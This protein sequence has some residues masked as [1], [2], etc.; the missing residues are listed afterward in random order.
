MTR[1]VRA[2]PN[3]FVRDFRVNEWVVVR[4]EPLPQMPEGLHPTWQMFEE[5][6]HRAQRLGTDPFIFPKECDTE[7]KVLA[8]L[9]A[10]EEYVTIQTDSD[11]PKR[12]PESGDPAKAS[13]DAWW[14]SMSDE[15]ACQ[16]TEK[17]LDWVAQQFF[18]V[19]E[20]TANLFHPEDPEN[21]G[22]KRGRPSLTRAFDVRMFGVLLSGYS[23][24]GVIVQG[25]SLE[26]L[27]RRVELR[28][29]QM[30]EARLRRAMQ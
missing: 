22:A 3:I 28:L 1:V 30:R 11:L 2:F 13:K 27:V 7:E 16:E 5:R 20:D 18:E 26:E 8:H 9:P 10:I 23:R 4:E 12:L 19:F 21:T 25:W 14:A 24:R 17:A 29:A 6:A 15:D